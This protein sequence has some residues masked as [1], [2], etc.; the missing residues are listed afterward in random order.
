[1]PAGVKGEDIT[2]GTGIRPERG[3]VITIH[4]RGFLHRGDQFRS[5]YDEGRPLRIQLGRREVIAGLERGMLGMRVGGRRR[6]VI[7]PHLAYGEAG[8]P[9]V[10]PPNAVVI[11]EVELLDVQGP[12]TAA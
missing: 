6:L 12:T 3:S 5:S 9:G 11:V 4:Y 8:V 7:S 2:V 1:M 10:I